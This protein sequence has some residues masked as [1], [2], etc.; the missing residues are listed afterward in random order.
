MSRINKPLETNKQKLAVAYSWGGREKWEMS[1]SE[2]G[3]FFW[4]DK[5][6]QNCILVMVAQL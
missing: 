3:T 6:F 4:S 5:M 1:A 2:Y